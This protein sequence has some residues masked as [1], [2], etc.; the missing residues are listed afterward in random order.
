MSWTRRVLP[1]ARATVSVVQALAG[2]AR[3]CAVSFGVRA[4]RVMKP[5]PRSVSSPR[6]G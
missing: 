3:R 2:N 5:I 4:R 6:C 1:L